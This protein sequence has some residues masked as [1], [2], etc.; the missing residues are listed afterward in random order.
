MRLP[1]G[2]AAEEL[3]ADVRAGRLPGELPLDSDFEGSRKDLAQ[4]YEQSWMAVVLLA[5]T[6]GQA[7]ML[8]LYRDAGADPSTG[9]LGRAMA[10][11]LHTTLVAFTGAWR[12]DLQRRLS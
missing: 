9:A 5:R 2:V 7:S 10:K 12:A 1:V 4:T 8:R 3:R 11:D 6:Y